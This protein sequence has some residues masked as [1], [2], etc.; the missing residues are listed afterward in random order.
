MIKAKQLT[1]SKQVLKYLIVYNTRPSFPI[2]V[3][4]QDKQK[5]ATSILRQPFLKNDL[6]TNIIQ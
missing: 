3:W 6:I 1:T 4:I 2:K 5:K